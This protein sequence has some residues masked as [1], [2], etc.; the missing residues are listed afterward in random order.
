MHYYPLQQVNPELLSLCPPYAEK[1][2]VVIWRNK[3]Y[4]LSREFYCDKV[5]I[6][7]LKS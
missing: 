6:K 7:R 5:W 1:G 4:F 3:R 2:K